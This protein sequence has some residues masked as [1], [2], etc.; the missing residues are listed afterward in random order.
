LKLT[1][2]LFLV[3]ALAPP[4]AS[5]SAENCPASQICLSACY[6]PHCFSFTDPQRSENLSTLGGLGTS[7]GDCDLRAG[8]V[9]CNC[10]DQGY[11]DALR[12]CTSAR[13]SVDAAD[14]FTIIGPPPGTQVTFTVVVRLTGG[15]TGGSTSSLTALLSDQTGEQSTTF[16]ANL[17]ASIGCNTTGSV[18]DSLRMGL[19]YPAGQPFRLEYSIKASLVAI[20]GGWANLTASLRITGLPPGVAVT[21]CQGFIAGDLAVPARSI[22]WGRLKLQYR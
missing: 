11:N 22:S 13:A 12:A 9:R 3:A 4:A 16:Q 1:K 15:L 2:L 14:D 17:P 10:Y 8:L 20:C 6:A 18:N 5:R 7:H 21:S 19:N